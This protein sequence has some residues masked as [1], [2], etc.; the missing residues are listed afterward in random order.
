MV[1][2]TIFLNLVPL[3]L[4]I[5][6]GYLATRYLGVEKEGVARLL[7]YIVTPCVIFLGVIGAGLDRS[8]F[9]IAPIFFVTAIFLNLVTHYVSK[10]IWD[11][12]TERLAAF[13]AGGGNKGYFGIPLC[14]SLFGPEALP[15]AVMT[16]FGGNLYEMSYGFYSLSRASMTPR[17]A[18]VKALRV[19]TLYV[20]CLA[21]ILNLLAIS[22]WSPVLQTLEFAKGAYAFL[23]M[24]MIGMGL[25]GLSWEKASPRFT[26]LVFFIKFL[27][28]PLLMLLVVELDKSFFGYFS[29]LVQKVLIVQS[30][31]PLAANIV[32][33]S[34]EVKTHP[35]KAAFAVFLSTIFALIYIPL[36]TSWLL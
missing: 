34:V 3:Y 18:L 16:V 29:P 36:V 27:V 30:L 24:L 12:G 15:A 35:E 17:Q 9:M 7:I 21:L 5:A 2:S 33:L 31:V 13:A 22:V 8:L 6:L 32:A 10:F 11:D 19:P 25:S 28:Q 20:F 23:G 4:L 1:F 26:S 14:L